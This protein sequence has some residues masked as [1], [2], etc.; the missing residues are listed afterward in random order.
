MGVITKLSVE[1]IMAATYLG[2]NNLVLMFM[3]QKQGYIGVGTSSPQGHLDVNGNLYVRNVNYN[4]GREFLYSNDSGVVQTNGTAYLNK[5]SM[6]TFVEGGNYLVMV[7]YAMRAANNSRV[8]MGRISLSNS[9]N[10]ANIIHLA[11]NVV[12]SGGDMWVND[13][14]HMPLP[15]GSNVFTLQY[16]VNPGGGNTTLTLKDSS[17]AVI[18]TS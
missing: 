2:S 14:I 8:G 17:I 6:Q 4:F 5:Y 1:Y 16:C 3:D 15:Q 10:A 9:Q 11:S 12:Q 7:S 18:R 13:H